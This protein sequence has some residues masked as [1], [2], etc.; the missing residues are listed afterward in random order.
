M[1]LD[2]LALELHTYQPRLLLSS[3]LSVWLEGTLAGL[4]MSNMALA[5]LG[6]LL[7]SLC[8]AKK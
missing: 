3:P 7:N 4:S 5:A 2:V 8:L 6:L 1:V